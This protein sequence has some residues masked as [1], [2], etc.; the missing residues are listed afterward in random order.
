MGSSLR[1]PVNAAKRRS[2]GEIRV[3]AEPL[4]V[5]G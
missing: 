1:I 4:E 2:D 5:L 3:V